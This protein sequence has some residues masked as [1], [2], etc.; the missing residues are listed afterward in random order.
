MLRILHHIAVVVDDL[1]NYL[2][3]DFHHFLLLEALFLPQ[4]AQ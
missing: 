2:A 3:G 1:Y 4:Q